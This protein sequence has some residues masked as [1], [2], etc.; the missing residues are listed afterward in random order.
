M[1]YVDRS[2]DSDLE[3][4]LEEEEQHKR[5]QQN[6]PVEAAAV[7]SA[8]PPAPPPNVDTIKPSVATPSN[9]ASQP[10]TTP[11][12]VPTSTAPLIRPR[13]VQ[14]TIAVAATPNAIGTSNV[15]ASSDSVDQ[16]QQVARTAGDVP[17]QSLPSAGS[18]SL[19]TPVAKAVPDGAQQ[20]SRSAQMAGS[21]TPPRVKP[22]QKESQSQLVESAAVAPQ[23]PPPVPKTYASLETTLAQKV[24]GSGVTSVMHVPVAPKVE[25]STV[26]TKEPAASQPESGSTSPLTLKRKLERDAVELNANG[27]G[28]EATAL[29]PQRKKSR[30]VSTHP[31][32]RI[33]FHVVCV[34]DEQV[35][36]ALGDLIK[37]GLFI[38][39]QLHLFSSNDVSTPVQLASHVI[40]PVT[41]FDPNVR[42]RQER[43]A[44][45]LAFEAGSLS[46]DLWVERAKHLA[47][48]LPGTLMPRMIILSDN[49]L[50]EA[51]AKKGVI[52]VV[53]PKDDLVKYALEILQQSSGRKEKAME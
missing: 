7:H 32:V 1:F 2:P 21:T 20:A 28:S 11:S 6:N 49:P 30:G 22:E 16:S 27:K 48:G 46:N 5:Q 35:R 41:A 8:P 52:D 26:Q 29:E 19:A 18:K 14:P 44:M 23:A 4:E 25:L 53:S 36:K 10:I 12:P 50:F 33:V 3:R 43:V 17:T 34:L 31:P 51:F 15:T 40:A 38:R 42:E 24:D 39:P 45:A 37:A 47:E 13:T 9:I